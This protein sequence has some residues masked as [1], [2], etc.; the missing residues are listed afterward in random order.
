MSSADPFAATDKLDGAM[1][2]A[3]ATRLEARGKHPAFARM[4]QE[5]LDAMRIDQA[6]NVLDLGCGTGLAARAVARRPGFQ[7]TVTGVDLSPHLIEA[8]TRLAAEEGLRERVV[9]R[10]GDTRKLELPDASFDAVVAHTLVSH[11]Q[12]PLSA[13]Q[14]AARLLKPGGM[15]GIFDGDYASLTFGNA[16]AERG[17]ACDEA[18]IRA[19]V[20]SP[21]AMRQMPRML[22]AAGLEVVAWFPYVLAEVGRADFWLSG[23]EVYRRLVPKAGTM[24]EHEANA[25]A[26]DLL[27][28]AENGVFFGASN[29]YSYVARRK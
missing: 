1:L 20:T 7:G 17:R 4:L 24:S 27:R 5:Y 16:D 12:D 22:R 29:F 3:I 10:A 14:L 19:L 28:D 15:L 26:G 23:I 18:L 6:R 21:S 13:V 9:F 8:A 2:D 25:W 11:L